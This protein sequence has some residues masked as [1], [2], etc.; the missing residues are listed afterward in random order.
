M[1]TPE[2]VMGVTGAGDGCDLTAVKRDRNAEPPFNAR[3]H[4]EA[5]HAARAH[6]NGRLRGDNSRQM[7]T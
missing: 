7:E 3:A 4:V 5:A 1:L 6:M 2:D